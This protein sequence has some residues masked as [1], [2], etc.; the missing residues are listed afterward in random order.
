M[1]AHIEIAI[2]TLVTLALSNG[3]AQSES[4]GRTAGSAAPAMQRSAIPNQNDAIIAFAADRDGN[5]AQALPLFRRLAESDPPQ[6]LPQRTADDYFSNRSG[7][8]EKI[9]EYYE[10]EIIER[11][12]YRAAASW[13]E[14]AIDASNRDRPSIR[15]ALRL[16]FL[17]ANGLGVPRDRVKAR[18]LLAS[19]GPSSGELLVLL[20]HNLLPKSPEDVTPSQRRTAAAIIAEEKTKKANEEA[21][22]LAASMRAQRSVSVG[23]AQ[24]SPPMSQNVGCANRCRSEESSCK[25]R[26]TNSEFNAYAAGGFNWSSFMSS[27]IF[28]ENC[29]GRFSDCMRSCAAR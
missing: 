26:N 29:S 12:D 28:A 27:S 20:D 19:G 10:K 3:F 7:A 25:S 17:Y 4:P 21:A 14:K 24:P 16:A 8:R 5:Y 23:T 22:R 13:Y 2:L 6:A 15:A 9:G 18:E 11:Q 1:R